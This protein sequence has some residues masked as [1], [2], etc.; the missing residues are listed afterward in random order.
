[1]QTITMQQLAVEAHQEQIDRLDAFK[2]TVDESLDQLPTQLVN[3]EVEVSGNQRQIER[4]EATIAKIEA[5]RLENP[6]QTPAE[7][8]EDAAAKKRLTGCRQT[9][10]GYQNVSQKIERQTRWVE[11][12]IKRLEG[13]LEGIQLQRNWHDS[14]I[15]KLNRER[16][17]MNFVPKHDVLLRD[18]PSDRSDKIGRGQSDRDRRKNRARDISRDAEDRKDGRI[19][20][21]HKG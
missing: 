6:L 10:V 5:R 9:I 20:K 11:R 17:A 13:R 8:A 15:H 2:P 18:L 7:K 3:L 14:Q 4:I 1:M 21:S 19:R 16:V 12:E